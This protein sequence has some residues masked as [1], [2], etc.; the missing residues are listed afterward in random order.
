MESWT[1]PELGFLLGKDDEG[2]RKE[3]MFISG[4]D[5]ND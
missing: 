4:C 5:D 2:E 3:E 1:L